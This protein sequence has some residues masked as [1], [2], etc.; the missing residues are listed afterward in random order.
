MRVKDSAC[1]TAEYCCSS[2]LGKEQWQVK[3]CYLHVEKEPGVRWLSTTWLVVAD[4]LL[5]AVAIVLENVAL[6]AIA[7]QAGDAVDTRHM[8]KSMNGPF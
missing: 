2:N 5:E 1:E 4:S 6:K 7:V 8:I 3:S